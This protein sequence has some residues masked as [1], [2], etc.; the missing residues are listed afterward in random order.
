MWP[1]RRCNDDRFG[2]DIGSK[3][4]GSAHPQLEPELRQLAP[5]VYAY[6]Q[7]SGPGID[8]ASLSNAGVIV[9]DD[10]LAIDALGPRFTPKPFIAAAK[11]ATGKPS[12]RL[13][14]TRAYLDLLIRSHQTLPGR[15]ERIMWNTMRLYAE[16]NGSLTPEMDVP[17]TNRAMEEYNALKVRPR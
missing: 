8:N 14:K 1:G 12:G 9:G 10:L 7:A 11:R 2:P 3:C 17:G 6:T 4:I 13:V 16:F 15:H 5:N